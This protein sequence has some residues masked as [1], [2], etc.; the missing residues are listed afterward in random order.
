MNKTVEIAS[1]VSEMKSRN[2][3]VFDAR[4]ESEYLQGHIPG[5]ICFSLLNDI[6]R[7]EVGITYKEQGQQQ[8]VL[9]GFELVGH[10][11]S[12]FAKRAIELAEGR[13]IFIYC[14]R[15]G[16]RS[17]VMAWVMSLA[18]LKVTLLKGGYKSY[19]NLCVQQFLAPHDLIVLAG[20]TGSGKSEMLHQLKEHGSAIIDLEGIANHK[21]SSFGALGQDAQPSQEQFENLLAWHLLDLSEKK[22]W[23]EDESRFVGKIRIPD[24]FFNRMQASPIIEV[25][26]TIENRSRRIL[27]EYGNFPVEQLEERTRAITKR[28]GGD[29]V[30]ESV[31][32]L[33]EGNMKG[34]LMPLLDY[35]DRTYVHS[36]D[37]RVKKVIGK[38]QPVNMTAEK[39][40]IELNR[41]ATGNA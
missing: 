30:K 14:W 11:F 29:R 4:S 5:A 19:R 24:L 3:I 8:A 1:F 36:I 10:K 38:I 23:I 26:R 18:G 25:E 20:A 37:G 13:E 22:I 6:E 32:A 16:L 40:C 2:V 15:G 33:H 12:D 28:M 27:N 41:I 39:I 21:G 9:K 34:W 31:T 7:K 17:N 35:Y